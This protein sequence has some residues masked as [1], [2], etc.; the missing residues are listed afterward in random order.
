MRRIEALTPSLPRLGEAARPADE[1]LR[2]AQEASLVFAPA[3]IAAL[4]RAVDETARHPTVPMLT[5]RGFGFLGP[6]GPLPRHLTEFARER[7]LHHGDAAFPR[8]LDTLMHR[9]GLLFYRAYAQGRPVNNLDRPESDRFAFYIGALIGIADE[10]SRARD[11]ASDHAKLYFAGLFSMQTRPPEALAAIIAAVL[12][13]PVRI[14]PFCG[15]WMTLARDEQTALVSR[16]DS[17]RQSFAAL[18]RGAVLGARCWDRQ[19]KFRIVF[20]PLTWAQY[21]ALLPGGDALPVLVALV[22]QMLNRELAW[23]A[24]LV[25]RAPE[26][27][28]VCLGQSG[29]LGLS[30]WLAHPARQADAA[31]LALDAD[32]HVGAA[33]QNRPRAPS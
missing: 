23:D 9:F 8:L 31:D 10:A 24:Q 25:L 4:T 1:P 11:A 33:L 19:H 20:G 21:E 29:R 3:P 30:T 16:A 13:V 17:D 5:Q 18:G 6:N 22:R 26:V 27:P 2:L 12:R 14:E 28:T 15:H 32:A 7:V